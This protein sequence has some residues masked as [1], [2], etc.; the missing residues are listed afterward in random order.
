M[1]DAARRARWPRARCVARRG[2]CPSAVGASGALAP[3]RARARVV[4][5]WA[6]EVRFINNQAHDLGWYGFE[7]NARSTRHDRDGARVRRWLQ[8]LDSALDVAILLE[9]LPEGL[10]LLR[11]RIGAYRVAPEELAAVRQKSNRDARRDVR[12]SAAQRRRL[13]ALNGVD[14]ALYHHYANEFKRQWADAPA[15][16]RSAAAVIR[17]MHEELGDGSGGC[18]LHTLRNMTAPRARA[19]AHGGGA[20]CPTALLTDVE[21]YLRHHRQRAHAYCRQAR[22]QCHEAYGALLR[23]CG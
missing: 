18:R 23:A 4:T 15:D 12:F 17:T 2:A 3:R 10:A 21:P 14:S 22:R 19:R 8:Q 7:G 1:R 20:K 13:M 11:H 9:R 6:D 5:W 16:V